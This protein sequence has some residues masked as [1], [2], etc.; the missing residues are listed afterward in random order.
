MQKIIIVGATSGIGRA[1]ARI[2]AEAGNLV[3]VTGRRQEL[4][5]SLQL[6]YPNH[7]VTE[8]YD[9]T[10]SESITHLEALIGKLGGLDLLIY[11][12]G[13]GQPSESLNWEIEKKTTGLNVNGFLE[14][15]VY[16]FNYFVRQGHGHLATTSS[17]ASIRGNAQAPAYS[18]SKSFQSV[19]FEGLHIKAKK[20][21][22]PVFVTDI[23]PGFVDAQ[24]A[25]GD[26]R[27]W[28]QPVPKVARQIV[29]AIEKKKW[30]VYI[31]RRWW[32]IAK[33]FKWVPDWIYHRIG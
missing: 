20:T 31:T 16:A 33:V 5:Y 10:G 27:F 17:I 3:G 29:G 30:R 21:K 14:T 24:M 19:Y 8:C 26:K 11:N 22:L 18:A 15:V 9:V 6:E 23:Q 4:L 13:Y 28:M 12:S 2:Y 7:I 25:K 1:L 32:L